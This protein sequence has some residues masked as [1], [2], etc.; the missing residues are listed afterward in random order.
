VLLSD[1]TTWPTVEAIADEGCGA[2]PTNLR[3]PMD[4]ISKLHEVL[5]INLDCTGMS[6]SKISECIKNAAR[7]SSSALCMA[8]L[9]INSDEVHK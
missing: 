4:R 7:R 3:N 9:E 2:T 1:R 5:D 6:Q 8:G